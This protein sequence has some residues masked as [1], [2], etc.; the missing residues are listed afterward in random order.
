[1]K[2]LINYHNLIKDNYRI[3][4]YYVVLNELSLS[5]IV[6]QSAYW[7]SVFSHR[8]G[9]YKWKGFLQLKLGDSEDSV[10][11]AELELMNE[12]GG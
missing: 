12:R 3:D 5:N 10:A 2:P 7:Y 8:R 11:R 4:H 9:D 1:M 6:S